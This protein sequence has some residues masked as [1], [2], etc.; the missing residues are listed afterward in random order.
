MTIPLLE[1]I[2][3]HTHILPGLDDGPKDMAGSIAIA[4]CY[5]KVGI[6]TVVATPHF[7][8]GTA[9]APAKERVLEAVQALQAS[10]D[11]A[12]IAL[13]VVAGME[14]A[15][16]KKIE[17][18]I[19]AESVLPLGSSGY[20]LIEP[21]FQGEQD[22]LLASL[23]SLLDQGKKIILA[24]PERV[25]AFQ[26]MP[27]V[28]GKLVE[29]GLRIQVNAGSMLGYFGEKSKKTAEM[30]RQDNCIHLLASDAHDHSK[31]AP[32]NGAEWQDL[33]ACPGGKEVIVFCNVHCAGM[34]RADVR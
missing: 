8:P 31:R 11:Q 9:W 1:F 20:F 15:Y 30:L 18:R 24:H 25:D 19:L 34:F 6:Q 21:S 4:R 7:L 10:L 17:E 16:H 22:G 29:Q 23:Q 14:I 2:D 27:R 26:R 33:L 13:K 3:M 28:L 5:E 32:L 12:N